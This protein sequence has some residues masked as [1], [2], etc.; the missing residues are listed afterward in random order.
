MNE[1][2]KKFIDEGYRRFPDDVEP[3]PEH[4]AGRIAVDRG[5][6]RYA[7]LEGALYAAMQSKAIN[8]GE[9]ER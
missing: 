8:D 4:P 7:F 2:V 5:N 9:R 1:Q 6:L 3:I